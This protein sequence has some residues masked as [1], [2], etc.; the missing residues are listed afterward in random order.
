MKGS[1]ELVAQEILHSGGGILLERK[2][3][4]KRVEQDWAGGRECLAYVSSIEHAVLVGGES[5]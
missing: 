2:E 4:K 1:K 3:R 5:G